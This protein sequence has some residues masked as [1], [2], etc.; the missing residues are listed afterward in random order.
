MSSGWRRW[1]RLGSGPAFL[2]FLLLA[3]LAIGSP[4]SAA[5]QVEQ[6][7]TEALQ[8]RFDNPGQWVHTGRTYSLQRWSPLSRINRDNVEELQVSWTFSTGELRGHE[9]EPLVIGDTMFVHTPFPNKVYALNLA[10]T[11]NP[12]IWSYVPDQPE[13]VIPVD[14]HV[15]GCPPRPEA[16]VY[17]VA[18]L[19]ERVANGESSPVVVKPY[20]LEK[21]G[22][23]ALEGPERRLHRGG[24]DDERPPR[25]EGQGLR[26]HLGR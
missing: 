20:E 10:K 19:Q 21:F 9:G 2:S 11:G 3:V 4:D 26:R 16:L 6:D 17:G 13:E 12:I 15:P 25:R 23:M 5:A 24:D 7:P 8:M 18:K 1:C 14:I 22:D